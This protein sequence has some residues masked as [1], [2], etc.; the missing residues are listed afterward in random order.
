MKC[1][2][3][4]YLGFDH[5]DKC[6][7][8]G[9]EFALASTS[10]SPELELP[11][12]TASN[13]ALPRPDELSFLDA[14]IASET[15]RRIEATRAAVDVEATRAPT[16]TPSSVPELPLF[17]MPIADDQPLITQA[18][19]PRA[20]L[21]VRRATPE[22]ARLRT[23]SPKAAAFDFD[24][25]DRQSLLSQSTSVRTAASP[26]AH[27]HASG[28]EDASVGARLAAV[29]TDLLILAAIDL[30]VLYFTMQIC[31]LTVDDLGILPKAPLLAFLLVQ[32]GGYLVTFTA[33]GRTLGKMAAG[34]KVVSTEETSLDFG[35]A[36]I[37][38]LVWFVLAVP[39]GLGLLS[40][41]SRDRRGIHDRF[42]GTRVV[43]G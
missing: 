33:G 22:V 31:G 39:A 16:P 37:R 4:G 7:N 35:R 32:N 1:P 23:I 15:V 11:L 42:A 18:S 6:R 29:L 12:K 21:A 5:V 41:L 38:E 25:P 17:G 3:C 36:F 28:E 9:Y 30:A 13:E 27:A 20:P 26:V 8:C 40:I 2:K 24:S 19:P 14:A 34:I 43:R 10:P